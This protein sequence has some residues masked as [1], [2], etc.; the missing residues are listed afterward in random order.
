[1]A[2]EFAF[3]T[4]SI[5]SAKVRKLIIDVVEKSSS[6]AIEGVVAAICGNGG[7]LIRRDGADPKLLDASIREP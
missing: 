5:Y 4:A 6:I 3:I 7:C 2:A 1:M